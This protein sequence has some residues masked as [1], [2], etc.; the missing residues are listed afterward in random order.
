MS[1]LFNYLFNNSSSNSK[2]ANN[3]YGNYNEINK[4]FLKTYDNNRISQLYYNKYLCYAVT[5]YK[6]N[7]IIITYTCRDQIYCDNI[8]L[9]T[10]DKEY[11][12]YYVDNSITYLQ[13]KSDKKCIT[14]T[15][16]EH[17]SITLLI[18]KQKKIIIKTAPR[19]DT[20][21]TDDEYIILIKT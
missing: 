6:N 18:K 4:S 3:K 15:D 17:I 2:L 10:N 16:D 12:I 13:I 20:I 9:Y 19:N 7:K 1:T 5:I 14:F 11:N 8:R 21:E